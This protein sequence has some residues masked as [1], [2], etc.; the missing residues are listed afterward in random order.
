MLYNFFFFATVGSTA[1][2]PITQ[3]ELL[4]A[5]GI[6]FRLEALV[7]NATEE[8]AE[9]LNLGYWR[10]VGDGPAPWLDSDEDPKSLPLGMGARYKALVIV[11]DS[12]GAPVG[13]QQL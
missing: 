3:S 9:A 4:G 5:L 10:L 8:Q 1:Y 11:N 7:R 2:G 13:F 12:Y 6:N